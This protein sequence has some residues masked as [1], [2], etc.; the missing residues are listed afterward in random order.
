MLLS[1]RASARLLL[2]SLALNVAL[3]V[4][5]QLEPSKPPK[6]IGEVTLF[7]EESP[8]VEAATKTEIPISKAPGAITVITAKQIRESGARTIPDLLRFV[9]GVNVRWNP[10]VQTIDVRGFGENPFSNRILILIDGIPYNSPDTGGFPLSPGFDIF[11]IQ[12]IKRIE[13]VKGPG[14]SLYGEN[15]YW[16]VLNIVTLSAEDI[17]GGSAEI[18]GGSQGTT[19]FTGLYGDKI[20]SASSILGSIR[21]LRTAF[22]LNFWNDDNSKFRASDLFL[23]GGHRDFQFSYYRHSDELGGFD[24]DFSSEGFPPG[25]AFKSAKNL[26]QTIDIF[27]VKYN[28]RRPNEPLSF[29]ADVS[30]SHRYGMHCAG[31]HAAQEK[32][33]FGHA[34]DHGYQLIGDFR[35]GVHSIRGHELLFG[36]EGRRLDRGDHKHELL[37]TVPRSTLGGYTKYASYVQDQMSLLGDRVR[38]VAGFRYDAKTELFEAKTSPRISAVYSPNDRTVL[39]AGYSTAFRFPNFSEL[40][41]E[42]WFLSVS[43]DL[44]L[45]PPM[46]LAIFQ[47]NPDLKPEEIQNFDLGGEYQ[48]SPTVSAKVDLFRS[49]VKNFLVIG[50]TNPPAPAPPGLQFV[51]QPGR[52]TVTGGELELRTNLTQGVTGFVNY[53]RQSET[54]DDDRRDVFGNRFEF[55]YAPKNK[56]NVGSYFGPFDGVRGSVE[57]AWRDQ[58]V[59]PQFWYLVASGFTD[60]TVHPLKAYGLLDARVSYDLP[61]KLG[62]ERPL[63][64]SIFGNNLTNEHAHETLVGVDSSLIGRQLFAQIEMHF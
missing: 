56:I 1:R 11:P 61:L 17:S 32:E 57:Y 50:F 41:Q 36:I 5:A 23:K 33:E 13:V 24:E 38:V 16:G 26:E 27:T 6:L 47:P 54:R 35:M 4:G 22:P 34:E 40:F 25:T 59:A 60:P 7:G 64:F 29:S 39:R 2:A 62:K 55:P 31:C 19:S 30:Y 10:M 9:A 45:F 49:Q 51:N 52:A 42:S 46:P 48:I 12:N 8:K 58:Y 15:A 63:R 20:G 44:G 53:A 28:H 21:L 18:Y 3:P 37:Q 43:N 14:S